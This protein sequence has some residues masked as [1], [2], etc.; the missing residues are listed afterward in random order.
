MYYSL[1]V[2]LVLAADTPVAKKASQ[3]HPTAKKRYLLNESRRLSRLFEA[4]PGVP[5]PRYAAAFAQSQRTSDS[6]PR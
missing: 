6:L 4:G 2:L 1:T 3:S 5:T